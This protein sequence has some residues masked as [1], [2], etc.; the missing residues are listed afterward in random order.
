MPS[1][2]SSSRR[3]ACSTVS[4]ASSLPPEIPSTLRTACPVGGWTAAW[5][6]LHRNRMPTATSVCLRGSAM[7]EP[8]T[9]DE[10]LNAAKPHSRP[11]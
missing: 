7:A 1:S 6:H 10:P 2:S 9:L 8:S 11:A 4:P 3:S 5:R